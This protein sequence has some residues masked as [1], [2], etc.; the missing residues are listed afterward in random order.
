MLVCPSGGGKARDIQIPAFLYPHTEVGNWITVDPKGQLYFVTQKAMNSNG[1]KSVPIAPFGEGASIGYNPM[2]SMDPTS[3]QYAVDCDSLAQAISVYTG[4]D[5]HWIDSSQI[6]ISGGIYWARKYLPEDQQNLVT[7]RGFIAAPPDVFRSAIQQMAATGDLLLIERISRFIGADL[8]VD[9]EAASI[10]GTAK[11][12]TAFIG[13]E[14]IRESLKGHGTFKFSDLRKNPGLAVFIILPGEYLDT[15]SKWFRIVVASALREL[16]ANRE[17]E[18]V[19]FMLDEFAQLGHLK[20]IEN[21]IALA[22]GYGIRMWPVLQ[23]LTQLR[24]LY[25]DSW[26]TFLSSSSVVQFFGV[27]DLFT[28]EWIERRSGQTT[29]QSHGASFNHNNAG[30]STGTSTGE[31]A[32]P[33]ISAQDAMSLGEHEQ[34]IIAAGVANANA[35]LAQRLPYWEI[36]GLQGTYLPDPYHTKRK[37]AKAAPK[38][39]PAPADDDAEP[40]T[41]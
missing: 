24:R 6:L 5:S 3:K 10:L 36:D 1:R 26:E 4:G 32:R 34:I 22:R 9:R 8:S 19:N 27:R 38:A 37:P 23:D 14:A 30:I 25:P 40:V 11:T 2:A 18:T 39:P 16:L 13:N 35:I 41:P 17:G 29:A 31:V 15:C 21:T 7:V 33:A 28:A 20:A 12:Q